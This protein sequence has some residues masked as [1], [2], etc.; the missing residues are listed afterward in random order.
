MALQ[1]DDELRLLD[2][3]SG[4][5]RRAARIG[6]PVTGRFLA[7]SEASLLVH[8]ARTEGLSVSFQGGW[9][10]AERVQYCFHPEDEEPEF[11]GVWVSV[12]WPA[13]FS[14]LTHRDLLGSL[15]GLGV[16]RS[17]FGDLI[18]QN[19]HA[20]LYCLP[21]IASRLPYEWTQAGRAS[22][23][24]A[25][26]TETPVIEQ[27]DGSELR[28][29]VA[30]VRMDAVLSDCLHLSRAK[31]ADMIRS[32]L[33]QLNHREETRVDRLLVPDTLLSVR[34]FGRIR[35]LEIGEPTRKGRFPVRLMIYASRS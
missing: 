21:E 15:M 14:H 13:R 26:C 12:T 6:R 10:N 2:R 28:I 19:D 18:T 35:V 32:G 33:V 4:E 24:A 3:A 1:S 30:S 17:F 16:D 29:T 25:L 23:Q 31:A 5:A 7:R 9:D 8:L 20:F 27:E 34:G 11:T 22:L